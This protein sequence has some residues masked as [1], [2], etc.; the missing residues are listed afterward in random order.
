[1]SNG[2][3]RAPRRASGRRAPRGQGGHTAVEVMIALAIMSILSFAVERT[4]TAAQRAEGHLGS[5]REVLK[6]GERLG[7]E[8]RRMVSSSRKLFQGDDHGENYFDA[9][10][11][12][13]AGVPIKDLRLPIFDEVN[14]LAP[15]LPGDPR[16]GNALLFVREA[17]AAPAVA[18]PATGVLRYIDTYRFICVFVAQTE[19]YLVDEEDRQ[20]ARDLVVWRSIAFPSYAQIA[21]V[22]DPV[23]RAHV[24]KD[25]YDRFNYE[26]CWDPGESVDRAFYELDAD[27]SLPNS[28]KKIRIDADPDLLERGKLVYANVQLARTD[29]IDRDRRAVLSV[30]DPD[31]WVPDGFEV[32]I[33]GPSGARKVWLHVVIERQASKGWVARHASTVIASTK[34][35]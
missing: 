10:D 8:L 24:V 9:L 22:S 19:R 23:Q 33:V 29:L 5:V 14:G 2:D 7:Y 21:S 4:I 20:T 26:Y 3:R 12:E 28:G 16:T 17:D 31:D 1:M 11:L 18:D 35:M 25:L 15:D 34:D 6:R 27:G 30:D 13:G 32:K